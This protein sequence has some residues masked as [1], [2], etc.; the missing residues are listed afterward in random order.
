MKEEEL[1]GSRP[2]RVNCDDCC[3]HHHPLLC[4]WWLV[5][6]TFIYNSSSLYC[7][8][9]RLGFI[10]QKWEVN[11]G[12]VCH[13][14]LGERVRHAW[15]EVG[16][17]EGSLLQ[18]GFRKKDQCGRGLLE[19]KFNMWISEKLSSKQY[20][21]SHTISVEQY[22]TLETAYKVGICP[23]WNLPYKCTYFIDHTNTK[24]QIHTIPFQISEQLTWY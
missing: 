8:L 5:A 2:G 24:S 16:N 21:Y 15:P 19:I 22:S 6:V 1:L 14:Y 20:S 10:T 23:G 3:G 9:I 12:A 13:W 18:G 17:P 11:T 7:R 4:C